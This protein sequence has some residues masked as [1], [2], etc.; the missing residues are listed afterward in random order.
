[1]AGATT[2]HLCKGGVAAVP[3]EEGQVQGREHRGGEDE[4]D[5]DPVPHVLGR[6][7]WV[8]AAWVQEASQQ[9]V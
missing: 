5:D 3:V 2:P 4:Q 7:P 9:H 1:M 6:A 8:D